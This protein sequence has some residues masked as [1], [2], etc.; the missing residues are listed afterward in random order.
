[1]A[2]DNFDSTAIRAVGDGEVEIGFS[3]MVRYLNKPTNLVWD[4][5]ASLTSNSNGHKTVNFS[6]SLC[7]LYDESNVS[8]HG[9]GHIFHPAEG[10]DFIE[11][12]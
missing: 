2:S 6:T 7:T 1:M 9:H 5:V 8:P 3:V 10:S 4:G 11:T 12:Y